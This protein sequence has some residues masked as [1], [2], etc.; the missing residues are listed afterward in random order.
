MSLSAAMEIGKNGLRIYQVANEVTAE[1]IANVNTPGYS[2]QQ[3]ILESNPPTTANGFPLGTGVKISAI[4]RVYDSLL[5]QQ[6]VSSSTTLGYDTTKSQILQQIEPSF[7]E[8]SQD[9]LGNAVSSFFGSWQD[10]TLNPSGYFERQAVLSRSQTLADNF[11]SISQTL[12]NTIANQD[13]ALVPLTSSINAT[14]KNIAQLNGQIKTTEAVSGNANETRD[15]RDQLILN[16]SKQIGIK[17]TENADG[18]TDVYVQNGATKNFLVQG[19]NFGSLSTGGTSPATTVT[20]NDVAGATVAVDPKA[21]SP[22]YTAPDG[23][24][25]WATLQLRDTIIPNYLTQVDTLAK[26]ITDAVNTV[27]S[28]GFSPTGGTGQNFFAST[29]TVA[30]SAANFGLAVGLISSTIAASSS[31]T[32]SGDNSAAL[33]IAQLSSKTTTPSGV[34]TTTFNNFYSSFVSTVGLDVQSSKTTVTQD[35]AFSKQ[36]SALRDSNS[37]VSLDEELTNLVKYQRSYQA[38]A[39]LISTVSDMM[40]VTLAMIR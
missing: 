9:G 35:E 23:G 20:I 12:T 2:R 30:G 24:Q 28:T 1:N 4:E 39:K 16:L 17:F 26:S 5:Q 27:H 33:A 29:A 31:A 18:T 21:A 40:D 34:P 22:L 3:V 10:L 11:H 19:A 8:T 36:L 7:N 25:L 38:S 37:G 32:L 14:L 6:L 13:A 15:Q